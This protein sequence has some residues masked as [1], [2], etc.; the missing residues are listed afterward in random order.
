[1]L[2]LPTDHPRPPVQTYKGASLGFNLSEEVNR[3]L[4]QLAQAHGATLYT[5]L[6]AAFQTLL[7]RYTGQEDLL[8]GSPTAG[9]NQNGLASL[10]GTL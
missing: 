1:M 2:D 9:R 5:T 10:V 8:V 3:G 4:K 7:F 6:L